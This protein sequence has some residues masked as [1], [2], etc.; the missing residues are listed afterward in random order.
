MIITNNPNAL[1]IQEFGSGVGF[2]KGG[3]YGDAGTG[4]TTTAVIV[5][6]GLVHHYK[7][8]KPIAFGDSETG[9]EYV[10]NLSKNGDP[11]YGVVGT[12]KNIVGPKPFR[13]LSKLIALIHWAE[14]HAS[15][16]IIDSVTHYWQE[17]QSTYLASINK[18]LV[19]KNK[20]PIAKLEFHHRDAINQMWKPFTD[21][22][23]NS[24]IHIIMCGRSAN[25]WETDLNEETGKRE[26][27]VIGTRMKVGADTAYEPSIICQLERVYDKD[28]GQYRVAT[29]TK[30]RFGCM[31]G[32]QI[33]NPT[34]DFFLP[35]VNL[36][37]PA[38][39]NKVDVE[40]MT[41]VV[42]TEDGDAEWARERRK[43]TIAEEN[44]Y[45]LLM[46]DWPGMS[47]NDKLAKQ[48]VLW[49]LLETRS[50]TEVQST[51]SDKIEAA[52]LCFPDVAAEV[53][54]ELA[55][56]AAAEAE[57]EAKAKEDKKGA[58]KAT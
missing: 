3:C 42:V 55:K 21:A 58:K 41:P 1:V 14:Q 16:L 9:A 50:W 56:A 44:L 11:R 33:A 35:Y 18:A 19:A 54:A 23:L 24:N 37:T 25:V 29:I 7:L 43:R 26:F 47:A 30:D 20:N 46:K 2:F 52:I 22:F 31:D 5:A 40:T 10:N 12:G 48:E 57:A 34:F 39:E 32:K 45:G 49:K 53:K 38:A 51:N 6:N 27:N 8:E 13:N 28:H 17:L 4:K 15:V 36:L